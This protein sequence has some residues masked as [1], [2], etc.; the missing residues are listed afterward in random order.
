MK[1]GI[2]I[3]KSLNIARR[4]AYRLYLPNMQEPTY[5]AHKEE[6]KFA[7]RLRGW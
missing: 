1:I 5:H 7:M 3:V 6:A 2:K 4:K